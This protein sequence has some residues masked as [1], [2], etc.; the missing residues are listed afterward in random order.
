MEIRSHSFLNLVKEDP[1][2]KSHNIVAVAVVSF[3]FSGPLMAQE[4]TTETAD[5][6]G[7]TCRDMM[8]EDDM[9]KA[10]LFGF[11][12]GYAAGQSGNTVLVGAAVD[13]A[14]TG[15]TDH[16]LDNPGD[17]LIAAFAAQSK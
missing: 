15:L 4:P 6:A 1:M 9:G 3:L 8:I 17:N 16:C 12:L 7:L 11:L 10:A 5:V 13:D 14:V 2:K